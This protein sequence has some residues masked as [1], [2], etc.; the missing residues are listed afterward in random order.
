MA[1]QKYQIVYVEWEDPKQEHGWTSKLA[2]S[3]AQ[4]ITVGFLIKAESA[5]Y[6]V[7]ESIAEGVDD[8]WGC[9]TFIPSFLVKRMQTLETPDDSP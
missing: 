1:D 6:T 2:E 3:C 8:A 7:V 4:I 9:S 5:G